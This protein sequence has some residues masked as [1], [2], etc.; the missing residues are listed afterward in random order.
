MSH[1]DPLHGDGTYEIYMK[2]WY[3]FVTKIN[4]NV[5]YQSTWSRIPGT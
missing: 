4:S 2:I 5:V 1:L 3:M